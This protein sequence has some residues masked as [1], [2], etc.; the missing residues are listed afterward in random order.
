MVA[1]GG[2]VVSVPL[3]LDTVAE[4]GSSNDPSRKS[5]ST[6]GRCADG[7][8]AATAIVVGVLFATGGRDMPLARCELPKKA[9]PVA[10][11]ATSN[12]TA[13]TSHIVSRIR[14]IHSYAQ[15]LF[16]LNRAQFGPGPRDIWSPRA[17]ALIRVR[18]RNMRGKHRSRGVDHD[19]W[20]GP[21]SGGLGR[22]P[23]FS[24]TPAA[25]RAEVGSPRI[26]NRSLS[27]GQPLLVI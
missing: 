25:G 22:G 8:L 14:T 20:R 23:G 18:L 4:G 21:R 19:L 9:L 26:G 17:S 24:F 15:V 11:T 1:G 16:A 12:A 3:V 7:R 2:T 6:R 5:D 10:K 27:P 13:N